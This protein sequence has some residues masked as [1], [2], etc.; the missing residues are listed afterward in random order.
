MDLSW[1]A[2]AI[3]SPAVYAA[4]T[5]G[6]KLILTRTGI[7]LASFYFYV[8]FS[9]LVIAG[10]I[11][12]IEG[13]PDAPAAAFWAAY[14]GGFLWGA[15][16]T[17]MFW[18]LRREEVSRVTPV[19]QSSPIFVAVIAVLFLDE[20]LAW[21]HW[22]AIML[23]V[24]GAAAVSL[25]RGEMG[26]GFAL[27]PTF[28][29][30]LMGALLIGIA[31]TLLKTASDDLSIWHSM[32]FRGIGLFTSLS[33]P[34]MRPGAIVGLVKFFR[35]PRYGVALL[36]TETLA[37]FV[38]NALLLTAIANGPVSL[39]S[40]LLGTRPVFVLGLTLVLAFAA[41]GLLED[42][43][44]RDDVAVKVASTGAVVGGIALIALA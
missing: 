21:Q 35:V 4:V 2:P 16:L 3:A 24:G 1:I 34:N 41:K 31:Q 5:I 44:G 13:I 33:L 11:F 6:D 18:V 40:A 23:V 29:M 20:A 27:R 19:W 26:K 8:G 9:Q 10:F 43:M 22:A 7:R 14:G 32:A 38:G 15:G 25:R 17:L 37:P 12:A 39:V 30:L 42:R 36:F 28:F